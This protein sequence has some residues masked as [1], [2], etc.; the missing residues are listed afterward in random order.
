MKIMNE[1]PPGPSMVG[2]G[3]PAGLDDVIDKGLR[4]DKNRRYGSVREL[5]DGAVRAYGL[6]GTSADYAQKPE[7]DIAAALGATTPPPPKP[8]GAESLPPPPRPG[9]PGVPGRSG[10]ATLKTRS[11]PTVSGNDDFVPLNKGLSPLMIGAMV[12]GGLF[13]LGVLCGVGAFLLR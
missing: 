11:E 3:V 6:P 1:Q 2:R 4:K 13:V 7:S 12:L 8:F 9:A 5:A 10:P